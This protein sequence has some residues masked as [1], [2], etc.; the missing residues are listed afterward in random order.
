MIVFI[1]FGN[2]YLSVVL[3]HKYDINVFPLCINIREFIVYF[4]VLFNVIVVIELLPANGFV[5]IVVTEAGIV[6][7]FKFDAYENEC[8]DIV[9]IPLGIIYV[10]PSLFAGYNITFVFV[11]SNKTFSSNINAVFSGSISIVFNISHKEKDSFPILEKE[12]LLFQTI[13]Q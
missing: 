2:T 3:V 9:V 10:S 8:G 6:T 13:S 7:V 12:I 11:L 4:V 1:V 5:C